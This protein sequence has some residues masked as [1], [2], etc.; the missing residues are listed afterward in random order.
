MSATEE[1]KVSAYV[2]AGCPTKCFLPLCWKKFNGAAIHA[3][4]GHYYCS[5]EC[6]EKGTRFNPKRVEELRPKS[7]TVAI[8]IN[9]KQ[10]A[11]G[12]F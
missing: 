1:P 3:R 12:R 9:A 2:K 7:H 11:S 8:A 10:K 5:T 4:D 6:A